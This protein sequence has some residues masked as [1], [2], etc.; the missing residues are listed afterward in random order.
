M[1]HENLPVPLARA[2]M[3]IIPAGLLQSVLDVL[4]R[5]MRR[6]HPGLFQN[7]ARLDKAVI[8]IEPSDL[9][10]QFTLKFGQGPTLLSVTDP[11]DHPS[12]ACVKGTLGVLLN[13]LEG[14]LDSDMLFFS[15]DLEITGDTAVVVGLRN[16]LDREEI[17]LLDD[18][19]G[20]CGPFAKP[21][22]RAIM[23][24]DRTAERIKHRLADIYEERHPSSA[25][26]QDNERE[27]DRLR[28]EVQALK[29]RLAKF[30]VRQKRMEAIAS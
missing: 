23:A 17:D 13:L 15:R 19:T 8:R 6:R 9:P 12:Q 30:E 3:R 29:T 22:R 20:L 2:A 7:L 26:A 28:A 10:H 27:C 21:A 25:I 5:R 16:T 18:I 1:K 11:K 14:R 24:M 4:M